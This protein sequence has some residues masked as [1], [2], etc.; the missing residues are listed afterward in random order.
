VKC[1]RHRGAQR[2]RPAA[3]ER[4][5]RRGAQRDDHAR[6]HDGD[7]ALE[8]RRARRDL[9]LRGGLVDAA[10]A[11]RLPLEMLYRVGDE[12]RASLQP[13]GRERRVE[14]RA[15]GPDERPRAQI[16]LVAGLLA[17]QHERRGG[18]AFAGNA[19]RRMRPQGAPSAGIQ[20]GGLH[21]RHVRG[22]ACCMPGTRFVSARRWARRLR[23]AR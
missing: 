14:Q 19:M 17:D 15:R 2:R 1:E 22:Q 23:A 7:L 16:F 18:G 21:R 13:C 5:Q 20:L 8:P 3:Q 9:L 12:E 4:T 6:L 10:L 11:A